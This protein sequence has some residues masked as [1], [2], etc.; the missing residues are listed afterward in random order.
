M[1]SLMLTEVIITL[2]ISSDVTIKLFQPYCNSKS[3]CMS[4]T[5]TLQ[6]FNDKNNWT[7]LMLSPPLLSCY[8]Q[9]GDPLVGHVI[10]YKI[11]WSTSKSCDLLTGHVIWYKI[12]WSTS[13]SCDLL[14]GHVIWYKIRWSTS[15][16]CDLLTG[17]VIWHDPLVNHV[18]Y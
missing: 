14:T 10:W 2:V 13:K 4:S 17:H 1:T 16:S 9:S 11:R 12:R 7:L 3:C 15:K 8:R 18:I 5:P 6:V